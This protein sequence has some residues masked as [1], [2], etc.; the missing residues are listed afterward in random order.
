MMMMRVVQL[1][2]AASDDTIQGRDNLK[3][4]GGDGNDIIEGAFIIDAGV[5]TI[6]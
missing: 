6:P 3:V 4:L 1:I 2:D 5:E